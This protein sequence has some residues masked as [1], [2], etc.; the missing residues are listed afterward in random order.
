MDPLAQLQDIALPEQIGQW[1]LAYGWWIVISLV[2]LL[3]VTLVVWQIKRYQDRKI[4]RS[5]LLAINS[6][7]STEEVIRILKWAAM[8]SFSR[9]KIA[10]S[11]GEG[12]KTLLKDQLP[13]SKQSEFE[14]L[15]EFNWNS[16][17]QASEENIIE[18]LKTASIFWLKHALPVKSQK[19]KHSIPVQEVK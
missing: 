2:L 10:A 4:Q 14:S 12:F 3:C 5:A 11:S 15:S 17:Y 13:N 8:T 9:S 16:Y 18:Q 19:T 1:P 6:A 7:E